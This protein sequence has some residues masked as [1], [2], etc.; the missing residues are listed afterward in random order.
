MKANVTFDLDADTGRERARVTL[1]DDQG[2]VLGTLPCIT[3]CHVAYQFDGLTR[4]T[5]TMV[6]DRKNLTLGT[7]QANGADQT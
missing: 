3:G 1:S 5:L 6:V 4:L 7:P 2:N